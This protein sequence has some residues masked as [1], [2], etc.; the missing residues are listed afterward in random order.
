MAADLSD[1]KLKDNNNINNTKII[2]YNIYWGDIM[3]QE[4]YRDLCQESII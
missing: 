3:Q 1:F 2:I 4:I